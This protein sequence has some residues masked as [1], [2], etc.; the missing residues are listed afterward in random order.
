MATLLF[1]QGFVWVCM[2]KHTHLSPLMSVEDVEQYGG[3]SL[4]QYTKDSETEVSRKASVAKKM[5]N[6]EYRRGQKESR[7]ENWKIKAMNGQH[8]RQTEF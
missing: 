6:V 8:L 1:L 4:K 3:H 2:G 5:E 7:L